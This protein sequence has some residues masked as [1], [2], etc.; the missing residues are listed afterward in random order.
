[1]PFKSGFVSIIGKPNSGKSTLLNALLGEK[2]SIITAK[3]QTTRHRIRG[4]LTT[5][6]YQIVFSDTPGVIEPKYGLQRTMMKAVN[7][8]LKDA[9]VILF[10]LDATKD[11]E[12]AESMLQSFQQLKI[13]SLVVINKMDSVDESKLTSISAAAAK[14]FPNVPV[15]FISALQKLNL[16]ILLNHLIALLPEQP[17]FFS[18]EELTDRSERFITS[19]LIREKIFEQ[20]QQEIPYSADVV[21][22]DWKEQPEIT[23]IRAEII[24]ERESQKAIL[25]GKGG[26][27]IK[28]LGIEARKSI[29][30]F[31]NK[32]I[33]LGLTVKV[34]P[35]WRNN[36]RTLKYLGYHS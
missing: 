30:Q 25:L 28:Q 23:K 33:F 29:E 22:Q 12:E 19:E 34:N 3:A 13:S 20:F 17:A 8:S 14:Y 1:M 5:E 10:L 4:I 35:G 36:D 6:E 16:D 15:V 26:S 7:E 9:D 11:E 24:V 27:A 32:K 31:L 21:I 18:S 2:I